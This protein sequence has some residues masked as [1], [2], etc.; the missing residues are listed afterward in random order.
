MSNSADVNKSYPCSHCGRSVIK[1]HIPANGMDSVCN[2]P[3]QPYWNTNAPNAS[4]ITSDG[5]TIYCNLFGHDEPHTADGKG[6]TQ[7]TCILP[8]TRE[9]ELVISIADYL[10]DWVEEDDGKEWSR[11]I[12]FDASIRFIES[13]GVDFYSPCDSLVVNAI[14]HYMDI[15]NPWVSEATPDILKE[16]CG[17]TKEEC[18][19]YF[20]LWS[21]GNF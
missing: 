7:H 12:P 9:Q 2:A 11:N 21:R 6:Y 17:F 19:K 18:E 1:I 4:V 3:M 14:R 13:Y 16:M 15:V 10:E 20:G 5:K 8:T